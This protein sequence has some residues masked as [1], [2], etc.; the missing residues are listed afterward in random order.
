MIHEQTAT[1]RPRVV[2]SDET[3]RTKIA[4]TRKGLL[5][6]LGAIIGFAVALLAS[7]C[8]GTAARED[9]LMPAVQQAWP[10]VRADAQRGIA[11]VYPAGAPDEVVLPLSRLDR[12]IFDG[13]RAKINL[14]DWEAIRFLALAGID[15]RLAKAEIGPNGAKSF[16]DR[17][18]YFDESIRS[19]KAR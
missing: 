14:L 5:F 17:V 18:F 13:N 8:A 3:D 15:D 11:A 1:L 12:A 16:R 7:S 4:R 2:G 9:V 6:A 10:G 19:L